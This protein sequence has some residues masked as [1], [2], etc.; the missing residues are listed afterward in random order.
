MN[1]KTRGYA[2]PYGREL[3]AAIKHKTLAGCDARREKGELTRVNA[4]AERGGRMPPLRFYNAAGD[5]C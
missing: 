5:E 3:E 4:E 2:E 1:A